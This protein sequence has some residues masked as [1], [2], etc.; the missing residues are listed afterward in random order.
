MINKTKI[1]NKLK[2]LNDEMSLDMKVSIIVLILVLIIGVYE[3]VSQ[4]KNYYSENNSEN[5]NYS[6]NNNLSKQQPKETINNKNIAN[7]STVN[8][9]QEKSDTTTSKQQKTKKLP[10]LVQYYNGSCNQCIASR[11]ILEEVQRE[12][13]DKIK[14]KFIDPS[15]KDAHKLNIK[16]YPT[17]VIYDAQGKEI[18]RRLGAI[19]YRDQI[20]QM[21]DELEIIKLE[22]PILDGDA[23]LSD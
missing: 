4:L 22:K 11:A 6:S 9:T 5:K 20:D 7:N 14:V 8:I 17:L 13:P 18:F 12:N 2:N 16:G 3:G 1:F 21:L 23:N 15:P 10:V 19:L